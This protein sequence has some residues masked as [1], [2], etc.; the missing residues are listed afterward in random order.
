MLTPGAH[1]G[2][3][4]V[5]VEPTG[6]PA[7]AGHQ[8]QPDPVDLVVLGQDRQARHRAC[9]L[10]GLAS[11]PPD[12]VGVRAQRLNPLLGPAQASGGNHLHCPGDLLDVP[13]RADAVADVSLRGGHDFCVAALGRLL[14]LQRV[15][16]LVEVVTEVLGELLDRLVHGLLGLI[17]P[18]AF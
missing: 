9:R 7:V 15:T 3:H 13:H 18:V 6:Q 11:H 17:A 16:L 2:P 4:N 14:L 1:T 5:G 10:G 12:R 8:Q